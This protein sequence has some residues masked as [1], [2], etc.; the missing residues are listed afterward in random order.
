MAVAHI[1]T[2]PTIVATFQRSPEFLKLNKRHQSFVDSYLRDLSARNAALSIGCSEK[3]A[4]TLGNRLKRK[5][6]IAAAIDA[7][8]QIRA[9]AN[10]ITTAYVLNGI[11]AITDD[12]EARRSDKLQ[13]FEML[14][15]WLKM[16]KDSIDVNVTH[17]LADRVA[18]A[19]Q[20]VTSQEHYATT[21]PLPALPADHETAE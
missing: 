21:E 10:G 6:H 14:G 16:W 18:Q 8:M 1:A 3:N 11:R 20:R 9:E 19:R 12:P 5:S 4:S 17:D 15:R 7:E 2:H 13:G